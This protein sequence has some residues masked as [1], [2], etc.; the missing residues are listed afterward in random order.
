[1]SYKLKL[2]VALAVAALALPTLATAQDPTTRLDI[3]VVG[4]VL[5]N[6]DEVADANAV[7][8]PALPVVYEDEAAAA[9]ETT[10]AAAN[11]EASTAD[12]SANL[13]HGVES[14]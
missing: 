10:T 2:G 14:E 13:G 6:G 5:N 4:A 1:M 7:A 12:A 9:T 3:T 11:A 8:A